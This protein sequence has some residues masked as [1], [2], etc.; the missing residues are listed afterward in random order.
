MFRG[1]RLCLSDYRLKLTKPEAHLHLPE[2]IAGGVERPSRI[3]D[4]APPP[5]EAP[6]APMTVPRERPHAELLGGG[7]TLAVVLLGSIEVRDA[8][9]FPSRVRT[10]TGTSPTAVTNR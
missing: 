3:F 10:V 1:P 7:E 6:E 8:S 5:G 4:V 9:R 2:Q